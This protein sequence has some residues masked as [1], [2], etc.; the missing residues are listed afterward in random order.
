MK[1]ANDNGEA[2]YVNWVTKHGKDYLSVQGIG[3]TKVIGRDRQKRR[4]RLFERE[5]DAYAYLSR[6][7]FRNV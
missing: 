1:M 3:D 5:K 7:G 4:S 6:H 2:V